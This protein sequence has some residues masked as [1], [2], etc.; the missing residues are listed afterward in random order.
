MFNFNILRKILAIIGY[1]LGCISF[2]IPPIVLDWFNIIVPRIITVRNFYRF[3]SFGRGTLLNTRMYICNPNMISLGRNIIFNKY[4]SLEFHKG[5]SSDI[6]AIGITIGNN[7]NFGKY[8]KITSSNKIFIGDG[9]LTGQFVL[10]TDNS[11]GENIHI[12]SLLRP[13][14]RKIF[15]KGP[16]II[17]N[18]VWIGDKVSVLPNVKIGNGV[19][20]AANAVVTKNVPDNVIVAGNPAK[21]VKI[22]R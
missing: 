19:I 21:I 15:S 6:N 1:I 16:V 2:I 3:R 7:C 18:N 4:C 17:G 22:L 12:E 20:V 11:H 14:Q 9:L 13:E 5:N 8:T 10:I